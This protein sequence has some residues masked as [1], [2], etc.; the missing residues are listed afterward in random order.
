MPAIATVTL[1]GR[2]QKPLSEDQIH[3]AVVQH[4]KVRARPG[5]IYWHCPN[6]GSRNKVEAARFVGLGV[7]PGI[8]DILCLMDG[9]LYG[10]ELKA[11]KGRVSPAQAAMHVAMQQAGAMVAIAFGL[12]EALDQL[13]E[14]GIL[15]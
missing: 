13:T 11:E 5:V 1:Q 3:R 14:W 2:R 4:L 10:L 9:T 12:D 7:K 15:C 6:G 8:P